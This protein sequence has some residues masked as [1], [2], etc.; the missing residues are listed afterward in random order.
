MN[1]DYKL[2]QALSTV[3]EYQNFELAAAQL[4]LSQSAIS[5]RIKQLEDLLGHPVLVRAKPLKPTVIGEHL[6]A[7]YQQVHQLEKNLLQQILPDIPTQPTKLAVA[8]N[9]DSLATWFLDALSPL[10]K[11]HPI[12]LDMII[13]N[14][15][16]TTNRLKSGEAFGAVS[17]SSKALPNFQAVR[18]GKMN[19]IMVASA[20]FY[21]YYFS[22]GINR[23]TLKRAPAVTFDKDDEMHFRFIHQ[24]FALQPGDYPC[25]IVRSSEAFIDM[26]LKDLAYCIAPEI[27]V[28]QY[29]EQ[30][31][32]LNIMPD[33]YF[34]QTLYWHFWILSKG[35]FRDAS[36][37]IIQ[38]AH[39]VLAQ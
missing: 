6:I 2:L 26:A 22:N 21:Q 30:D 27:Q 12:E 3:I 25:H 38:H 34:E 13:A 16:L 5:Q 36:N 1:I 32:L 19:Y 28:K 24:H 7:H 37:L 35:I 4:C 17:L 10:L 14:E 29:L 8:L 11:K 23:N 33:K 20:Q 31:I 18:L 39:Q 15:A 9:A